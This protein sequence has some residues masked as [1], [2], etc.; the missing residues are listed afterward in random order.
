MIQRS[1]PANSSLWPKLFG[2]RFTTTAAPAPVA[3]AP[4][5]EELELLGDVA[6]GIGK[7]KLVSRP[8]WESYSQK[9]KERMQNPRHRGEITKEAADAA[10]CDLVVADHGAESCGDAVRL[11][12]AVDRGTKRIRDAKFQ[13]FGCATAIAASD[14]MAELCIGKT[15]PEASA[16]ITN[17]EVERSLRD[18]PDVPAVP[19]QKMHCSVLAHDVIK[20]AAA[21]SGLAEQPAASGGGGGGDTGEDAEI[22]CECAR[23]S[24]GTIRRAIRLNK[25]N[26]VSQITQF[27]KAGGFCKSCVKPG[28]HESR[29]R[30][31]IDILREELAKRKAEEAAA[32]AASRTPG[33]SLAVSQARKAAAV[34][35]V[36]DEKVGAMLS[37]HGGSVEVW[38]V[39]EG[40]DGATKVILTYLGACSSCSSARHSTLGIIQEVLRTE[41]ADPKLE[42]EVA[43][44]GE[45]LPLYH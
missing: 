32:A 7:G 12:W 8:L 29:K 21:V 24:L 17:L 33:K 25:L 43:S 37:A 44:D 18:S 1:A 40:K 20:K 28:G 36:I 26:T 9:V 41:L 42:V 5:M 2:V 35:K 4:S 38:D 10:G 27:T 11:F 6:S 34:Q 45:E 30:F 15:V 16:S 19:P 22:V 13:T 23:A 14:V 3:N 39:A 31:L